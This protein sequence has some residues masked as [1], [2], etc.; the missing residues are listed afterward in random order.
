MKTQYFIYILISIIIFIVI[1]EEYLSKLKK[2]LFKEV[3][4]Q[5]NVINSTYYWSQKSQIYQGLDCS[6]KIVFLGTSLFD[7]IDMNELFSRND[8]VNRGIGGDIT[9]GILKRTDD[10]LIQKPK[11]IFLKIGIN[12]I[13]WGF[14][15]DTIKSNYLQ[16]ITKIVNKKIRLFIISTNQV[17]NKFI[18]HKNMNSEAIQ[19]NMY[20]KQISTEFNSTYIDINTNLT[21][22]NGLKNKFTPDGIHLNLSG[23]LTFKKSIEP[24]LNKIK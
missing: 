18:N 8:I 22:S 10:Y 11:C 9:Y 15:I 6:N 20:L 3:Q 2:I 21:D 24:Y 17:S 14:N 19:L 13:F 4:T 7:D 16:I 5:E 23:Y 12:D 1:K